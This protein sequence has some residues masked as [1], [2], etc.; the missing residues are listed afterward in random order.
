MAPSFDT[1]KKARIKGGLEVA[2]MIEH[3]NPGITIPRLQLAQ[4][5]DCHVDT[6]SRLKYDTNDRTKPSEDGETRGRK[7]KLDSTHVDAIVKMYDEHPHEAPDMPWTTQ[8]QH[9]CDEE[10]HATTTH[11]TMGEAGYKKCVAC[12]RPYVP[13]DRAEERVCHCRIMLEELDQADF[14]KNRYSEESH[15]GWKQKPMGRRYV[16]R[17]RG[18]RYEPRNVREAP[19]EEEPSDRHAHVWGC[20]GQRVYLDTILKPYVGV[21]LEEGDR[22]WR[23]EED[24]DSGHGPSAHNIVRTWKKDVGLQYFFNAPKSPDLSPIENAWVS[25]NDT[26]HKSARLVSTTEGLFAI[27]KQAWDDLPQSSMDPW[28]RSARQRYKDCVASGGRWVARERLPRKD[29]KEIE[30]DDSE[31]SDLDAEGE[32]WPDEDQ[33]ED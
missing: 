29:G 23:L 25:P 4:L 8:L 1:P 6:I 24:N 21:W 19:A 20:I 30:P 7:R 16:S 33:F 27:A 11:R 9:A 15:F 26:V 22:D 31:D 3:N 10:V 17:K 28:I 14:L 13:P 2:E 5:F 32:Y 12:V 18:T